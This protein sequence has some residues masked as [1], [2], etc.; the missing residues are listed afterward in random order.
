MVLIIFANQKMHGN[1]LLHV[2]KMP[3]IV[4]VMWS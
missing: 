2:L 4:G 1:D 3:D